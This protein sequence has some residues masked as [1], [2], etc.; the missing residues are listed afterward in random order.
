M[1]VYQLLKWTSGSSN[2]EDEEQEP[3]EEISEKL[4]AEF[5]SACTYLPVAFNDGLVSHEDQLYFYAR[6][7]LV[8]HG[9][10]G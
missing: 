3:E 10:A 8:T 7:K 4:A 9:K 5:A 1:F 2:S 6:Y